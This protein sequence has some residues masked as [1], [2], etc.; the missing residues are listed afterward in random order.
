MLLQAMHGYCRACAGDTQQNM[1]ANRL[2]SLKLTCLYRQI[3]TLDSSQ[4]TTPI[5]KDLSR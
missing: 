5:F 1:R 4:Q 2:L 3:P